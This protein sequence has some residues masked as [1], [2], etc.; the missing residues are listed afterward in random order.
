MAPVHPWLHGQF[1][2]IP[3]FPWAPTVDQLGQVKAVDGFCRCVVVLTT[4]LLHHGKCKLAYT[5]RTKVGLFAVHGSI[6]LKLEASSI[7]ALIHALKIVIDL[8]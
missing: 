2:R 3:G 1:H 7:P 5:C 4:A 6:F 8:D